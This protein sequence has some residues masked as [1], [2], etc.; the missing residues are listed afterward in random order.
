MEWLLIIGLSRLD[1]IT[2]PELPRRERQL[3]IVLLFVSLGETF[4]CFFNES[5]EIT[6]GINCTTYLRIGLIDRNSMLIPIDKEF[7]LNCPFHIGSP[8]ILS[9]SWPFHVLAAKMI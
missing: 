4:W 9:K 1:E 7:I 5:Q 6:E 8:V 3:V 2:I